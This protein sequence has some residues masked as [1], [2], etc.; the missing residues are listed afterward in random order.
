MKIQFKTVTRCGQKS[1]E[2][3]RDGRLVSVQQTDKPLTLITRLLR[4][5]LKKGS[6]MDMK[7][8]VVKDSCGNESAI[9]FPPAISHD[10]VAKDYTVLGAGFC[11]VQRG[12]ALVFG[13]SLS[14]GIDSRAEDEFP[15]SIVLGCA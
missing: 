2:Y 8:V 7:Y 13:G 9:V 3:W 6:R 12:K 14:L 1:V 11:R 5:M 4:E 15:V 10:S